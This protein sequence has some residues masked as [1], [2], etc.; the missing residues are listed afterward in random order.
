LYPGYGRR[1]SEQHPAYIR[2]H[3][4][5]PEP[6][7]A[8]PV[9]SSSAH[10][11]G[12][13]GVFT[14]PVTNFR[15]KLIRTPDARYIIGLSTI[16]NNT[17]TVL[18][19]Y[20][21]F[22]G[23]VLKSRTVTGQSTVLSM[24][25]DGSRFMSGFTLYDTQTLNA[26]GQQTPRIFRSSFRGLQY[27]AEHRRQRVRPGRLRPLRCL[28]RGAVYAARYQ[29]QASTLLISDPATSRSGWGSRSRRASSPKW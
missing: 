8:G 28:Q 3:A 22:S 1:Q 12:A 26:V 25:P 5:F 18:Y 11:A 19:L 21:A 4:G 9:S 6:G 23:T 27:L 15:G 7:T 20:E 10:P 2:P 14:R 24:S 16:N 13:P 29:P 17:Q